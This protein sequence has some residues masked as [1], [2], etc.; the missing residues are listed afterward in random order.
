MIRGRTRPAYSL[1]EVVLASAICATALVP[2]LAFMRDGMT[3]A[4][5]IDKRHLL[6]IYGVSK[7]E[8]QLAIVAATWGEGTASGDFAAEGHANIRF[9]ATCSDDLASGGIAD[10][11]MSVSVTAY[12]DDDGDDAL[13]A[14]EMRTVLTTKIAKL[15]TYE[16]KAGG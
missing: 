13:D 12:S 3:L 7:M 15:V 10:R 5:T 14:A 9:T 2:A 4:D 11:L 8:E 6:V 1:L 16:N